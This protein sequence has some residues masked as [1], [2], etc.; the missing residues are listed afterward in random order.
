[1]RAFFAVHEV[2]VGVATRISVTFQGPLGLDDPDQIRADL[3]AATGLAWRAEEV[4]QENVLVGGLTEILLIAVVSKSTE[5]AVSAVVDKVKEIV[6]EIKKRR[7]EHRLKTTGPTVE[8]EPEPGPE[9]DIQ[10]AVPA[11]E[12]EPARLV[13]AQQQPALPEPGA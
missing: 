4:Y 3:E 10:D 2:G 5:M 11:L 6:E 12:V 8:P 7:L 9:D 13:P 1:V